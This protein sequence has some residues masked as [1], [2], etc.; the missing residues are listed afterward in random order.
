MGA[1]VLPELMGCIFYRFNPKQVIGFTV[2]KSASTSFEEFL[3]AAP[4][5]A[6]TFE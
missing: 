1:E 3:S 6:Q 2:L 5:A 4:S